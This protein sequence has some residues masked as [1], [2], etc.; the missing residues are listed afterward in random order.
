MAEEKHKIFT[1]TPTPWRV[2]KSRDIV[3]DAPEFSTTEESSR[4]KD[5]PHSLKYYG[6]Y[7]I[8]E[9]MRIRNRDH[10]LRAVNNFDDMVKVL[11]LVINP[12]SLDEG[13]MLARKIL[14]QLRKE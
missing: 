4:F 10:V 2:G 5:D 7:L 6:G 13:I 8:A 3:S 12:A 14:S 9:S 1:H 11:E